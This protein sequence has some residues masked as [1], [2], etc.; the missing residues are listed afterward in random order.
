MLVP[1]ELKCMTRLSK[2]ANMKTKTYAQRAQAHK[3]PLAKQ[4]LELME[5]KR[6]NLALSVDVT[7][8]KELLRIVEA[9]APHLCIVKVCIVLSLNRRLIADVCNTD[10]HRHRGRLY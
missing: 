4:L 6:T 9:A 10:T 1:D 7:S 8:S 5:R 2:Q 3:H